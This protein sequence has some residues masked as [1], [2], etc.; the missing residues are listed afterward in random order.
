MAMSE[1]F[2]ERE[3]LG[4]VSMDRRS[5]VKKLV[6]GAAFAV[7]VIA[8]FDMLTS[9]SGYGVASGNGARHQA[10]CQSKTQLRDSLKNQ[11]DNLPVGTPDR[12]RNALQNR[13]NNLN[14]YIIANCP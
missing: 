12:V 13:Y 7:P 1:D 3:V 10:I 11:I 5:F 6:A 14:A 4:R 2:L 9:Q 8:S